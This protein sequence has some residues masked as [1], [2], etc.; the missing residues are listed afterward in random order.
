M[1]FRQWTIDEE[2][3]RLRKQRVFMVVSNTLNRT[4]D[5]ITKVRLALGDRFAG[6]YDHVPPHTTRASVVE[7]AAQA[8]QAGADLIVA[9]G[10]GSVV[11]AGKAMC[12]C[13]GHGAHGRSASDRKNNASLKVGSMTERPKHAEIARSMQLALRRASASR[14]SGSWQHED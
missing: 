7:A 11:V 3:D 2:T 13:L 8:R 6:L 5:E 14:I 10:D 9:I 4:T 1:S 12:V